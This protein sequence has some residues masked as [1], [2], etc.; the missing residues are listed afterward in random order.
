MGHYFLDVQYRLKTLHFDTQKPIHINYVYTLN[1][2]YGG[3]KNIEK[4]K[5]NIVSAI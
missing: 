3:P 5:I 1:E 4:I 2:L